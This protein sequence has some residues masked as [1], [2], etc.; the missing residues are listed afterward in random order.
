MEEKLQTEESERAGTASEQES[1]E[2]G[3]A[4]Q[5]SSDPNPPGEAPGETGTA[6][7]G[8]SI[9]TPVDSENPAAETPVSEPGES[10]DGPAENEP[11]GAETLKSVEFSELESETKA[12]ARRSIEMLYDISLPVSVE[13]GRT[14]LLIKELLDLAPGS[15][16]ELDKL[17]G[18]PAEILVNGKPVARGEVVVV[19]ENFGVRITSILSAEERV[20]NLS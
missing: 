13:L 17:A 18:E 8:E 10:G 14:S 6:S 15:I 9:E 5:S 7:A 11:S 12:N 2:Q 3:D 20:K 1:P 16:V 4:Q 19:D